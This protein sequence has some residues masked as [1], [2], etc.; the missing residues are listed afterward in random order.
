MGGER[1]E[2]ESLWGVQRRKART[3]EE[4]G[5]NDGASPKQQHVLDLQRS[6]GNAAVQRSLWGDLTEQFEDAGAGNAHEAGNQ[7]DDT[8]ASGGKLIEPT[9][10]NEGGGGKLVEPTVANEGGGG[11]KL[12]EPTVLNEGG[13]GGE[14]PEPTVLDEGGQNQVSDGEAEAKGGG[15]DG[16]A[17]DD[18]SKLEGEQEPWMK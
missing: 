1:Q 17:Q 14:T 10:A 15:W 5:Q 3:A 18:G 4:V 7:D 2:R 11:G 6:A 12:V 9:V 8:Q 16:G 13:A